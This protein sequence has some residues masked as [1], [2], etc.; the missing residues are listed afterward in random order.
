LDT[1]IPEMPRLLNENFDAFKAYMD[2]FYN[3]STGIL[4]KPLQTTGQV[5]ATQ[6]KFVTLTADNLVVKNQYT[7]VYS[8]I[9]TADYDWY[10]AYSGLDASLRDASTW[11]NALFKYIDV[12]KPYYKINNNDVALGGKIALKSENISQVVELIFNATDPVNPYRILL[13]PVTGDTYDIAAGDSSSQWISLICIGYD[14]SYG[15]SWQP[16]HFGRDSST[17]GGGGGGGSYVLPVA[18]GATLGGVRTSTDI[19]INGFGQIRVTPNTFLRETS[20]GS[21]LTWSGGNLNVVATAFDA[22]DNS[23]YILTY[24]YNKTEASLGNLTSTKFD[25]SI[26]SLTTKLS[27]TDSSLNTLKSRYD[28]TEAS[29]G[30]L[31][32]TRFDSSISG[33]T[34]RLNTTD[35]SVANVH[36][37]LQKTEA[38]LGNLTSVKFDACVGNLT[39]RLNTTDA[40]LNTLTSIVTAA[41]SSVG[42]LNSRIN[43][44]DA[45][46]NWLTE[47]VNITDASLNLLSGRINTTDSSLNTL[48]SRVNTSDTS[49]NTLTSRHNITDSSL[50]TLTHRVNTSDTSLNTLTTRVSNTE[51]S[52]GWLNNNTWK[53][54]IPLIKDTCTGSGLT[55]VGGLIYVDVSTIAGGVTQ[56]YVDGSLLQ[57]DNI[58]NPLLSRYNITEVSLGTLTT[59]HNSTETSLGNLSQTKFDASLLGL[60]ARIGKTESSLGNLTSVK[61]DACVGGLTTRV[62]STEGSIGTLTTRYNATESSLNTL[63]SRH[64]KTE[65]SLGNLTQ[66]KFDASIATIATIDSNQDTSIAWL[67]TNTIKTSIPMV[68]EAS[69]GNTFKWATGYLDVSDFVSKTYV[70]GSLN[71]R[72]NT[73]SS[74]N[75]RLGKV[76]G[77]LYTLTLRTGV[78][79]LAQDALSARINTT[80]ISLSTLLARHNSTES[81]L[82]NL[83]QTKFDASVASLTTRVGSVEGSIGYLKGRLDIT[84]VSLSTLKARHDKTEASLGNLTSVKFDASVSIIYGLNSQ[85]DVSIKWLS[86]N[87]VFRPVNASDLAIARYDGVTGSYLKNSG[88]LLLDTNEIR[89]PNTKIMGLLT[90]TNSSDAVNKYYIDSN[91]NKFIKEASLGLDFFWAAGLLEVSAGT[92]D[93]TKAYVDASLAKRDSSI[94]ALYV[95]NAAQEASLNDIMTLNDALKPDTST[96]TEIWFNKI[97]GYVYGTITSP[98]RGNFTMNSSNAVLGATNLIISSSTGTPTFPVTFKKLMGTYDNSVGVNNFIYVQYIDASNQLYNISKIQS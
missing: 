54:S 47:R 24:R 74:I 82:G 51:T 7:N 38:S 36:S 60:T 84:D 52:V 76:D 32:Q 17:A 46:L 93:V 88:V 14:P 80:D 94:A 66:T 62:G 40:S 43:I 87:N 48:T 21:G 86:D 68:K 90:P 64:D 97:Q 27:T 69:L 23:V 19:T 37:R 59:R 50:N 20:I 44:T 95:Q 70:D 25:T 92:G 72:D 6:G 78:V 16:Y 8:N 35:S 41:D 10:T 11:E 89:M 4:I 53:T 58:I 57:R 13:N 15:S 96:S 31:S 65:A 18:T 12:N 2:I 75:Y 29:L 71:T 1:F 63:K 98:L 28:K 22:L 9:T 81:S 49:L 67:N 34:N 61:F 56:T 33:L 91:P 85:Q 30:N 79:E 5:S 45:S 55:W 77:S 26:S 3:E 83:S 73:I 42:N 39:N